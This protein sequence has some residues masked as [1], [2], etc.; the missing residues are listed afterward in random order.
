[1]KADGK[2]RGRGAEGERSRGLQPHERLLGD[3]GA[4]PRVLAPSW[5]VRTHVALPCVPS[6]GAVQGNRVA[7]S[8]VSPCTHTA[9]RGPR[10]TH[11][12]HPPVT[13]VTPD[14]QLGV[15]VA[16][17]ACVY[18]HTVR[19]GVLR[20]PWCQAHRSQPRLCLARHLQ[21]AWPAAQAP[22]QGK[23]G[24]LKPGTVGVRGLCP[25]SLRGPS[26]DL[27]LRPCRSSKQGGVTCQLRHLTL[28][29]EV[30]A[31]DC[32]LLQE[33][34]REELLGAVDAYGTLVL[35]RRARQAQDGAGGDDDVATTTAVPR[36]SS[37]EGSWA[38]VALAPAAPHIA[39]T[40]RHLARAVRLP[41]RCAL[42]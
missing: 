42:V 34:G 12:T 26:P 23:E 13:Q 6:P 40:A 39:A 36:H 5:L 33:G 14:N 4:P 28:R 7:L 15:Y 17:N 11:L 41:I 31:L 1:M 8:R 25:P 22:E 10:L 18:L 24:I 9:V 30:Q 27:P 35:A 3:W 16:S 38:G 29:S 2:P 20:R 32:A 37:S 19:S 21:L